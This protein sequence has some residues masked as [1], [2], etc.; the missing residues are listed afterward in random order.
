MNAIRFSI[1]FLL[2]LPTAV[3]AGEKELKNALSKAQ[4]M[5]RQA[6]AEKISIE[7]EKR[8]VQLAF[9]EYKKKTEK[10]RKLEAKGR[11]KQAQQL[12]AKIDAYKTHYEELKNNYITLRKN[13]SMLEKEKSAL[14]GEMALEQKKFSLCVANNH[15]LFEVNKEILGEYENKGLFSVLKQNEPMMGLS[16]VKIEN[17]VQEYQYENEDL[18]VID[19]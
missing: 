8:A 10:E 3:I 14:A 12:G 2:V 16:K 15:K 13:H 17:L 1:V 18:L 6:S 7:K 9:D 5:L 4:Y 19:Y 11:K